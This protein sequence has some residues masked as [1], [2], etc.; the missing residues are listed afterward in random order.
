MA[1]DHST[2]SSLMAVLGGRQY[3]YIKGTDD[4][5]A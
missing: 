2:V 5:H 1:D 3:T 4:G